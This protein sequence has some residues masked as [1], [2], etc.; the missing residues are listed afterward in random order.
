MTLFR[1]RWMQPLGWS[2]PFFI[3]AA[4]WLVN[5][6]RSADGPFGSAWRL[7]VDALPDLSENQQIVVTQWAGQSPE[8]VEDR[9]TYPLSC[10]LTGVS[11][12]SG[13]SSLS[14]TGRSTV[15]LLFD[16]TVDAEHARTRVLERMSALPQGWLPEGFNRRSVRMR[17]VWGRFSGMCF[18]RRRRGAPT[19]RNAPFGICM[20]SGICTTTW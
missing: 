16:E 13:I 6:F 8:D 7:N 4:G 3:L 5:P 11:G 12:V 15:Y 14:M 18:N 10:H 1:E 9:I 20:N 19:R 17:P 2:L